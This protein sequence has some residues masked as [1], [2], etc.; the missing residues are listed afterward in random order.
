MDV[1]FERERFRRAELQLPDAPQGPA[2]PRHLLVHLLQNAEPERVAG[3][4]FAEHAA[5]GA[6]EMLFQQKPEEIRALFLGGITRD[7]LEMP[8]SGCDHR[9]LEGDQRTNLV[10]QEHPAVNAVPAPPDQVVRIPPFHRHAPEKEAVRPCQL[11]GRVGWRAP[12]PLRSRE[13]PG[14]GHQGISQPRHRLTK[15]IHGK[16]CEGR[17]RILPSRRS[18]PSGRG[19]AQS[20]SRHCSRR[21]RRYA[22]CRRKAA[23]TDS[24]KVPSRF[25]CGEKR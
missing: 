13:T 20:H 2:P 17:G 1:R 11:P 18:C 12:V 21:A 7:R 3:Q 22:K 16:P 24:P 10:I 25:P 23:N 4:D 6:R 9:L 19:L 5:H 15:R 8:G 14:P